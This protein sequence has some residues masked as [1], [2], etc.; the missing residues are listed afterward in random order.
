MISD[1][2]HA[3]SNL[4]NSCL[5]HIISIIIVH[6]CLSLIYY[7]LCHLVS[8]MIDTFPNI[9]IFLPVPS[10]VLYDLCVYYIF[11]SIP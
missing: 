5:C 11:L 1:K 9:Y 6:A 2:V 4:T 7:C 8:D 3:C 10:D